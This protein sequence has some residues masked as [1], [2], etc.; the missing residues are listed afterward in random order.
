[1]T[2]R[3]S[4]GKNLLDKKMNYIRKKS[5]RKNYKMIPTIQQVVELILV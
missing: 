5:I 3:N 4:V 1:M 2:K